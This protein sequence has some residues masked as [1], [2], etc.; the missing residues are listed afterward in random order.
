[1]AGMEMNERI[2]QHLLQAPAITETENTLKNL[3]YLPE[4]KRH[5]SG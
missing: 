5:P 1:M 2:R 4:S 3:I